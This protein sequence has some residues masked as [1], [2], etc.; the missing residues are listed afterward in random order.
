MGR[1]WLAV[2]LNGSLRKPRGSFRRIGF[3]DSRV[4]EFSL[5]LVYR[6]YPRTVNYD[7]EGAGG[8]H[9]AIVD[10]SL[11]YRG[12]ERKYLE[13][14]TGGRVCPPALQ[15]ELLE[16]ECQ[17]KQNSAFGSP[18][19]ANGSP[20]NGAGPSNGTHPA[21]LFPQELPGREIYGIWLWSPEWPWTRM[22]GQ[23]AVAH[24]TAECI[25]TDRV[26]WPGRERAPICRD[27]GSVSIRL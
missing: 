6:R 12:G 16:F 10:L 9:D 18:G 27:S 24:V 13:P 7:W 1:F 5:Q 11:A 19:G 17:S 23:E 14:W 22:R 26:Y 21:G 4:G 15:K 8:Y 20:Q 3:E 2:S 25:A